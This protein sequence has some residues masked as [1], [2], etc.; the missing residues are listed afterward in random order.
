MKIKRAVKGF[1]LSLVFLSVIFIALQKAWDAGRNNNLFFLGSVSGSPEVIQ[2]VE[3]D[4]TPNPPA[5]HRNWGVPEFDL[6][7]ESG[8]VVE[9]SFRGTDKFLFKKNTYLKL[10]VASLTKLMTAVIAFENFDLAKT[11]KISRDA[12]SQEGERGILELDREITV[13]DLLYITLIESSNHAAYALSEGMD[14][15]DFVRLMNEKARELNMENTFFTKPA[16]LS[17]EN[18]STAEDLIKT[19]KYILKKHP[20]ISEI[21]RTKEY[22]LPNYGKLTNTDELLGEVP[23]IVAGKTGLLIEAKGC[24]LLI[25]NNSGKDS[26][27]IFVVLGAEDRFGEMRKMI[28]WVNTAYS[29]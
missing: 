17:P 5:P 12:I 18:I 8:I 15:Y 1:F 21:S 24:L 3:T 22:D 27:L 13:N 19:A 6:A 25:V 9:S 14:K 2:P 26:Y 23:D 7:A 10:P 20:K 11:I 29:W 28:E 16:G 4:N